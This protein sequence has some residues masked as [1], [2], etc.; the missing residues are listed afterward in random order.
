MNDD[1]FLDR[2]KEALSSPA[3]GLH[4]EDPAARVQAAIGRARRTEAVHRTALSVATAV[5]VL[6]VVGAGILGLATTRPS[7]APGVAVSPL[8]RPP[9]PTEAPTSSALPLVLDPGLPAGERIEA[10]AASPDGRFLAV[11]GIPEGAP[12]GSAGTIGVLTASGTMVAN[13]TGT[14]MAWVAPAQLAIVSGGGRSRLVVLDVAAGSYK[15][16]GTATGILLGDGAGHLAVVSGTR[17]TVVD[18]ATG[19]ERAIRGRVGLDWHGAELLLVQPVI[20]WSNGAGVPSGPLSIL[21]TVSGRTT[22][23]DPELDMLF[24]AEFSPDGAAVACDCFAA[25]GVKDALGVVPGLWLLPS[26]GGSGTAVE[27]AMPRDLGTQDPPFAWLRNGDLVIATGSGVSIVAATGTPVAT[28]DLRGQLAEGFV[29]ASPGFTV[30]V[31][32]Y[33]DGGI[34]PFTWLDGK[35]RT[36]ASTRIGAFTTPLAAMTANGA[37]YAVAPSSARVLLVLRPGD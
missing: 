28:R 10:L 27:S 8:T 21:D 19:A 14:A 20:P 24:S 12:G 29:P 16:L 33:V 3:S 30:L 6:L 36:V 2:V 22:A 5:G 34:Q 25:N 11:M 37:T 4:E 35:G 9:S 26:L 13:A 1:E 32:A 18:L 17:T 15:E 23:L 31:T 7:S